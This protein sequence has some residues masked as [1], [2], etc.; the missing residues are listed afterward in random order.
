MPTHFDLPFRDL[1]AFGGLIIACISL[2]WNI[3]NEIRN[4]PK[5]EL[6]CMIANTIPY[7]GK[8]YLNI[9]VTNTGKRPIKIKG[10]AY[11]GYKWWWPP[12][13]KRQFVIMPRNIPCY[14]KEGEDVNENFIYTKDDFKKLLKDNIKA[15]Y[16]FDTV[17]GKHFMP[18]KKF[19]EFNQHV[20]RF[21]AG[22]KLL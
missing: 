5:A 6:H 20:K 11:V 16:A 8:D 14:L 9:T 21:T 15:I 12:W 2:G 13:K 22:K 7:D 10:V 1:V 3:L 17:G 19:I 18:W 4:R